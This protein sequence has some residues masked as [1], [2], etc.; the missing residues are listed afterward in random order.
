M[1]ENI[2]LI[3]VYILPIWYRYNYFFKFFENKKWFIFSRDNSNIF[4]LFSVIEIFLFIMSF[5][6]LIQKPFEIIIFNLVFYFWIIS[7]IFVLWKLLRKKIIFPIE[8]KH[9]NKLFF[10]NFIILF[11]LCLEIFFIYFLWFKSYIY[12]YLLWALLLAPIVSYIII[13]LFFKKVMM[14]KIAILTGW[15]GLEREIAIKSSAFF[16][17]YIQKDFDRYDL[18]KQLEEF[19]RNKDKYCLAVPVFHGEYGEDGKIFAV[20]D[21]LNIPHTFSDYKT[22]GLCLDKEKTNTLVFQLWIKVPFQYIA[23]TSES[24][25]ESYPVIMKPNQWGSSFHTYKINNHQEFYDNFNKTRKD[26]LDDILIQEFI[27]W[28]E[29]SV[30]VVAWEVLPI[31]KVEKQDNA[32][33]FDYDSKY[34]SEAKMKETFPEINP[35]LK[36]KLESATH[37]IY[38]YFWIKSMSRIDF[39]VRDDEVFFLEINT[40]PGMTQWSILPKAWELTGR[41]FEELVDIICDFN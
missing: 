25:P 16:E 36:E 37:K 26:L 29:Y 2:L 39:L 8:T 28:D 34:E 17:K 15:P 38:K 41:S 18:P 9:K 40:I 10:Y 22:H 24:F 32:E 20:L 19:I 4:H 31:M 14:K 6:I 33:L 5:G 30:P 21:S 35:E 27:I 12:F 3:S 11:F 23:E 13:Q 7:S 1:L